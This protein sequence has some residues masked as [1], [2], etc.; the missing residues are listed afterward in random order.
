MRTTENDLRR[1]FVLRVVRE[2]R[3]ERRTAW[4]FVGS[5]L[6]AA[7]SHGVLSTCAGLL[8]QALI[9]KQLE[10]LRALV[11]PPSVFTQPLFLS[12]IGLGAAIVKTAAG[13]LSTYGQKTLVFQ[14]GNAI[15][16]DVTSAIVAE[17]QPESAAVASH[18]AIT[19]RIR[20]IERGVDEGVLAGFRA[21]L[22][23]APLLVALVA[24]S[25]KLGFVALAVLA[26][27]AALLSSTRRFARGHHARS[28]RL[29]EELHAAVDGLVRQLD[30]WRT[31]GAAWEVQAALD[32]A[33]KEAGR[34][35][36]KAEATRAWISG[37]NE[38]L[39]AAVLFLV[40]AL[41]ERKS[42]DLGGG[43]LVAFAAVFFMMYRPL[44]DLGDARTAIER[45]ADSLVS[46]D[47]TIQKNSANPRTAE[48]RPLGRRRFA[49]ARLDIEQAQ[50]VLQNE[51]GRAV[52]LSALPGEIVVITGPTGSG[53]TTLLRGLLGLLPMAAGRISYGGEDL[54]AAAVGPSSRPFAWLPQ[55]PAIVPGTIEENV[56][57]GPD[58]LEGKD[59]TKALADVGGLKL[60]EARAGER[61]SAGGHELSG[62]ERQIVA[63][64]R[65][66]ASSQPVLL[67]DEPTAGLDQEAEQLVLKALEHQRGARTILLVTHRPA[68][69]Q[70]ADRVLSFGVLPDDISRI[71]Q[72]NATFAKNRSD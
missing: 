29:A 69:L 43:S 44:R 41:V 7:L 51:A 45:A 40:V 30:L 25:S 9:G 3:V 13:A 1:A 65:A 20:D 34:A 48:A 26:P 15:R 17:G 66:V 35:A 71:A 33:G 49:L 31:Y 36:A 14:V 62:G 39:A 63:L 28:I 70:I 38:V 21:A 64:A 59:I 61:L 46:L 11:D 50:F 37:T 42:V 16:H 19:I 72:K 57:L 56:A 2:I 8:G 4:I 54:S 5:T 60:A 10:A 22:Y 24:L 58:D 68:P 12:S 23:L 32:R 47:T 55:E 6:V 67:L 27:F 18:A 52:T 53:K